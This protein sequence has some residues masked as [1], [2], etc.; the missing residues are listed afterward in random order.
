MN[1]KVV[2]PEKC[3]GCGLCVTGCPNEVARLERKPDSEIVNPPQNFAEWEMERMKNR[4][5]SE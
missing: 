1:L 3:T 4:G 5:L 2:D